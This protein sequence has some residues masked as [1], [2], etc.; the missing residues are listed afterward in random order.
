MIASAEAVTPRRPPRGVSFGDPRPTILVDTREQAPLRF[1]DRVEVQ[2]ATLSTGDYSIAG[3]S[4]LVAIE[5][6]SLADLL[7]CVGRDRER[8]MDQCRRLRDY[9]HRALVVEAGTLDVEA[10]LATHVRHRGTLRPAHVFGTAVALL[11][12]YDVP[13]VWAGNARLAADFTERFLLRVHRMARA[14]LID[15]EQSKEQE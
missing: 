12:D 8:F 2:R 3:A 13:V 4:D 5:R 14:P 10:H 9:E 15:H 7:G 6:K 1:S 11:T